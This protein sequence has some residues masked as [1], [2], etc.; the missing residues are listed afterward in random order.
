LG[1]YAPARPTALWRHGA[2]VVCVS[3]ALTLV[4]VSSGSFEFRLFMAWVLVIF[5]VALGLILQ[6]RATGQVLW[7]IVSMGLLA[8]VAGS[9]ARYEV[10]YRAYDGSAD[11]AMY[12]GRGL[13]IARQLWV[14]DPTPLLETGERVWGT[15]FLIKVS[16]MVIALSGPSMRGAF[17]LFAL[18][19]FA[20]VLLFAS[21]YSRVPGA[22][23]TIYL[24]WLV[25]WPSLIF[26]PSSLGKESFVLFALGLA[27]WGYVRIPAS[28]AWPA[29]VTGLLLLGMVRPHLA[30]VV[31][32][33]MAGAAMLGR[34]AR[35]LSGRWYFQ[36]VFWATALLLTVQLSAG[37]L[38]IE[39][40]GAAV[41]LVERTAT[42]SSQ[43]G[44]E[45]D[46]PSLSPLGVPE[47]FAR[48]LFRPFLWE[49]NSALMLVSAIEILALL[50]TLVWRRRQLRAS[51]RDWRTHRLLGFS[52]AFVLLYAVMLGFAVSNIGIIARQRV[53]LLPMLLLLLQE[54]EPVE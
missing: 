47:A 2:L 9:V 20:G 14:L 54:R 53:L 46:S 13:R 6:Y 24:T 3:L 29:L 10:I 31:V 17:L 32:V 36:L 22:R 1:A 43:G 21:A 5:A 52:L 19:A 39:S 41:D 18:L 28:A 11:A 26:W 12:Y 16:G 25:L 48:T 33:A 44:S 42:L 37:A 45:S 27:V 15:S 40:S 35:G 7:I 34:R 4:F 49:A 23:S 51:L 50:G 8:K 38:G 30:G